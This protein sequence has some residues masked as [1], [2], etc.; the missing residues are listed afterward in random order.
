MLGWRL[1]GDHKRSPFFDSS[2]GSPIAAP[3]VL[4][5]AERDALR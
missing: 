3:R 4:T 5:K 1:R 2:T